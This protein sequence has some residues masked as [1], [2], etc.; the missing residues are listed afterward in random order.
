MS[1]KILVLFGKSGAG[2][3][4][5]CKA[6]CQRFNINKLIRITSRPK[7]EHET[8][9]VEYFFQDEL[10]LSE[11]LIKSDTQFLEYN[12]F[13]DWIYATPIDQLKNGWNI[14]T[15][16]VDAVRQMLDSNLEIYPVYID[17]SDKERV[18][19][20]LNREEFPNIKEIARRFLSDEEDYSNIDFDYIK[21]NNSNG[22]TIG[23]II[24]QLEKNNID[25]R[26]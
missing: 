24:K 19:R 17:V 23:E 26:N 13:N 16:D 6:L 14:T 8:D 25:L 21:I 2:K 4:T 11:R 5:I 18:L 1:I 20:A 10:S 9:G 7:R 3:D 15:C 12:I 22:V